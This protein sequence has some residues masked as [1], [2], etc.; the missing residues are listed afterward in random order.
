MN[1]TR[2]LYITHNYMNLPVSNNAS[3]RLMS[4]KCQG[5][6]VREFYIELAEKE[7]DFWV[8]CDVGEYKG[9]NLSIIL[10]DA[11]DEAMLALIENSD[12]IKDSEDLYHE[13]YR[14]QFH[15]TSR[16]GWINDP[17]GLVYFKGEYHLFYQHN[18]Y[19]VKWSNMHWGHAVSND[20]VHWEEL[21][22]ALYPDELGAMYS[23][24]A[25]VDWNH[26]SKFGQEK[27]ETLVLAYT[28]AG[29]RT[30]QTEGL[31]F[32]Q[33]LAYS[34]DQGR[35]FTKYS[36]NPIIPCLVD[37]NRDPKIIWHSASNKWIMALYLDKNDYAL[38]TSDNIREWKEVSRLQI[39]GCEECPDIFELKIDN[40]PQNTK[41][42]FWG[43][44]GSYL[45]GSFD[46]E[47]FLPE[48]DVFKA[49][50]GEL[51]YAAQSWSDIPEEDG[52]RIQITWAR[53]DL[54]GMAFNR[55]MTFPCELTL[56][57]TEDGVRLFTQPITEIERLHEHKHTWSD[58]T[59]DDSNNILSEIAGEL[60]DIRAQFCPAV[61]AEVHITVRGIPIVYNA[62]KE[63]MYCEGHTVPLKS[64]NG[65][66]TIQIL[67]DRTIMEIYGN[68]GLVFI[69]LGILP[70]SSNQALSILS[71]GQTTKL[72][73][74]EVY[75]LKSVWI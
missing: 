73:R 30:A 7:P 53:F 65:Q 34:N 40:N 61:N 54:P 55:L 60:F 27:E 49:C 1:M 56:R 15:F 21:G 66:I 63:E 22:I 45:I 58:I 62:A 36:N 13:K 12:S 26:T 11:D 50:I 10:H 43:G 39:P 67:I 18:P 20:L 31:P 6:T 23:G 70:E 19:G 74:L 41:W 42:V 4:L 69:P 17:N 72:S 48:S 25:V 3:K 64:M 51:S 46:G 44:N 28:A 9:K 71:K 38:F 59:I 14:P 29:D 16:R 2:E 57:T 33:C 32:T 24:S 68:E 8:Y 75:G 37:G 35:T 52:R 47:K 5:E